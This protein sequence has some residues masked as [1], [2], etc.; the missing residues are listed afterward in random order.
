MPQALKLGELRER[1][2]AANLSS[3]GKKADLIA[4]LTAIA[5]AV[6]DLTGASP[7]VVDLTDAPASMKV[8]ELKERLASLGEDTSG[9][10]T[11]LVAR[12]EAAQLAQLASGAKRPASATA[13]PVTAPV[14][15]QKKGAAAWFWAA[16]QGSAR[17]WKAYDPAICDILEAALSADTKRADIDATYYVDL[18]AMRRPNFPKSYSQARKDD[19]TKTRPVVRIEDGTP[20]K[21]PPPQP[22]AV[23]GT[24]KSAAAP[25]APL[26]SPA[27]SAAS[28]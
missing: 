19:R 5:P 25:K 1:C 18:N 6:V 20:P 27:F 24:A 22:A 4:R 14:K 28:S 3:Q 13:A 10:K 17:V 7:T 2:E 9:K 23:G 8:G 21:D 26:P 16:D 15:K 12:L 11:E